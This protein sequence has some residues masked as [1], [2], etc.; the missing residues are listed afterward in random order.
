MLRAGLG[1]AG[2]IASGKM[3]LSR[4]TVLGTSAEVALAA[5]FIVHVSRK[6]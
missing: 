2:V 1:R 4:G 5:Q 3:A 6:P